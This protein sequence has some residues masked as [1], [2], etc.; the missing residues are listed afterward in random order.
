MKRIKNI[1]WCFMTRK[2]ILNKLIKENLC[3]SELGL[4]DV[5]IK[6]CENDEVF[7]SCDACR[8]VAVEKIKLK[9][10][11]KHLTTNK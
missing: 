8:K 4:E 2:A 1:G 3:P 7:V 11:K 9:E 5:F 10:C 6:E